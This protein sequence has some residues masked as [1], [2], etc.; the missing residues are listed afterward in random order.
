MSADAEDLVLVHG[1]WMT[2]VETGL[3][4]HRLAHDHGFRT[5][6]FFYHTVSD[7]LATNVRH[8][9]KFIA[10][11]D[12]P[13]IHFV[14]HS[15]GGL[16]TLHTLATGVDRPGRVVCIGAPLLGSSSARSLRRWPGGDWF[17]GKTLRQIMQDGGLREYCGD[18]EVGVI[19][20]TLSFGLGRLFGPLEEPNDGTVT[21]AETRLPGLSDHLEVAV[22]HTGL[23]LT[24]RV[25]A[26]TAHFL[27]RGRFARS[28][29][30]L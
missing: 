6:Q 1:L 16:V 2:G 19:A 18:R 22:T 12:S 10:K 23:L 17:I 20:G 28:H 5:H 13:S 9:Q 11:I 24:P 26:Q 21:V 27:R 25:A 15:L 4:R 30:P 7:D 8:L 3:L 14:A 29:A